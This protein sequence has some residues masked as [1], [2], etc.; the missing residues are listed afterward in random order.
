ML[1]R[2][3]SRSTDRLAALVDEPEYGP[4]RAHRLSDAILLVATSLGLSAILVTFTTLT[5]L[6]LD[7]LLHASLP[8]NLDP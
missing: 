1:M 8:L 6:G 7:A 2:I 5:A 4:E 3:I